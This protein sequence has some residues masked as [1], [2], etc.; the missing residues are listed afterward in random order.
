MRPIL[1]DR[2]TIY[3]NQG[4]SSVINFSKNKNGNLTILYGPSDTGKTWALKSIGIALGKKWVDL[5]PEE[6]N[7]IELEMNIGDTRVKTQRY[8]RNNSINVSIDD[9]PFEIVPINKHNNELNS[10]FSKIL[11][12]G[13]DKTLIK[14]NNNNRSK[15]SW[16][17]LIDL[18]I[19]TSGI[20]TEDSVLK[21]EQSQI[22]TL[23]RLNYLFN[24]NSFEDYVEKK[25]SDRSVSVF[26]YLDSRI[27]KVEKQLS[28]YKKTGSKDSENI[29]ELVSQEEHLLTDI[30]LVNE[31]LKELRNNIKSKESEIDILKMD[32][33]KYKILSRQYESKTQRLNFIADAIVNE[34]HSSPICPICHNN[35][36]LDV[37]APDLSSVIAEFEVNANRLEDL[38]KLLISLE[39]RYSEI[40]KEYS[41]LKDSEIKTESELKQYKSEYARVSEIIKSICEVSDSRA[42]RIRLG[43]ELDSL[44]LQKKAN[45]KIKYNQFQSK[46]ID[47]SFKDL[48]LKELRVALGQ[49]FGYSNI[50][51]DTQWNPIIDNKS[52]STHG[53]G[54]CSIINALTL[55]AIALVLKRNGSSPGFIVI[56]SP[57]T[58]FSENKNENNI[59]SN[60][61]K[62]LYACSQEIQIIIADNNENIADE[63]KKDYGES[64]ILFTK[65][66][67]GRYGLLSNYTSNI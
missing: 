49:C 25:E 42:E 58:A 12:F 7:S 50:E 2:L 40:R 13:F 44:L 66:N 3:N 24:G 23:T 55:L 17:S 46:N 52:K 15:F 29:D 37:N 19:H 53:S 34:G 36:K 35:M 59:A 32:I 5:L 51:L 21:N 14:N 27:K 22:Y 31:Q 4:E 67:Q 43:V 33:D 62:Y 39:N 30:Q 63:L 6:Y 38:N 16:L 11:E 10:K 65:S 57:L 64:T 28:E 18:F 56:D 9:S 8:R 26:N 20:D 1:F 41:E 60:F 45:P 47:Q 48:V 54:Y 61:L